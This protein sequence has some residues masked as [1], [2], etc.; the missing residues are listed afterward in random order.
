METHGVASFAALLDGLER[1]H[2]DP[3][4]FLPVAELQQRIHRLQALVGRG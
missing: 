4:V 1:L 2:A 3:V